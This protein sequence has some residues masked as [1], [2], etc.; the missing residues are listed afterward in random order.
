[1][2]EPTG[3]REEVSQKQAYIFILQ[4]NTI[5][6]VVL[7]FE[8]ILTVTITQCNKK[9]IRATEFEAVASPH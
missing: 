7:C 2:L 3:R 1:M 8:T 6:P 5:P 9:S 4:Y